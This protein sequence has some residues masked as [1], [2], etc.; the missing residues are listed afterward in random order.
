MTMMTIAILRADVVLVRA[1]RISIRDIHA[2]ND[3]VVVGDADC[4]VVVVVDNNGVS[5]ALR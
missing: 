4:V 3:C 5:R 1:L 2:D